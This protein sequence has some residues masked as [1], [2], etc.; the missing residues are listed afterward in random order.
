M[1]KLMARFQHAETRA[2]TRLDN[3][4]ET[5]F[6]T[7]EKARRRLAVLEARLGGTLWN[8]RFHEPLSLEEVNELNCLRA[9]VKDLSAIASSSKP[10]RTPA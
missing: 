3:R 4:A 5:A 8:S 2:V 7:L 6:L 1:I 9:E 10:A